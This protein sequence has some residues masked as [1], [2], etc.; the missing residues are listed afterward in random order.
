MQGEILFSEEIGRSGGSQP[1]VIPAKVLCLIAILIFMAIP[2]CPSASLL[3]PTISSAA[4]DA[5]IEV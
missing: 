2:L 5:G 3:D 4:V 1:V